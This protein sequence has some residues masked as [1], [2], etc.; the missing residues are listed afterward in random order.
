MVAQKFWKVYRKAKKKKTNTSIG[1]LKS[2]Q[3]ETI[4]NDTKKAKLMNTFFIDIGKDL[5]QN[6]TDK[7]SKQKQLCI[8]ADATSWKCKP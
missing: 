2:L 4:T 8:P 3:G 5:T 1:P 6:F 7:G